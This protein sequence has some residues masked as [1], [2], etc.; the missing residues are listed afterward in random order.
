MITREDVLKAIEIIEQYK[1]EQTYQ[2]EK[3]DTK[4]DPR[5]ILCLELGR[6]ENH[7]LRAAE[8]NTIGELLAHDRYSL[9]RYRNIGKKSIDNINNKLKEIGIDTPKFIY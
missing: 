8:I 9:C 3:L 6:R 1:K 7:V 4:K 5:D 2:I